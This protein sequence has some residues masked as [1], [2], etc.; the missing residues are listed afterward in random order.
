MPQAAAVNYSFISNCGTRHIR[1]GAGNATNSLISCGFFPCRQQAHCIKDSVLLEDMAGS[2]EKLYGW[3]H[4]V[5]SYNPESLTY[6][7]HIKDS[8]VYMSTGYS[9]A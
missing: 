7:Y 9:P 4:A 2:E 5:F 3:V 1:R 8:N 6:P